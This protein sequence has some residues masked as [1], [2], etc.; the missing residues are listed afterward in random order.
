[1]GDTLT[2]HLEIPI[3]V[4]NYYSDSIVNINRFS[5]LLCGFTVSEFIKDSTNGVGIKSIHAKNEFIYYSQNIV[6]DL[7]EG[8]GGRSRVRYYL[9]KTDLFVQ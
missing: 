9:K 1:M 3:N 4:Y 6:P 7:T 5:K 2:L 8:V